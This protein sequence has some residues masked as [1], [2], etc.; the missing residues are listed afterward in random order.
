MQTTD[1]AHQISPP[2]RAV[3]HKLVDQGAFDLLQSV[4]SFLAAVASGQW[5]QVAADEQVMW[6]D[7]LASWLGRY[8]TDR[9]DLED[10]DFN[11]ALEVLQAQEKAV[12]RR[13]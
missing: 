2:L 3:A 7:R 10:E 11:R 12:K 5:S 4:A 1:F 8:T 9:W 6:L 13:L